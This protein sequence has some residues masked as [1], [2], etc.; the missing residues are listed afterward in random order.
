M[1]NKDINWVVAN[2]GVDVNTADQDFNEV[3]TFFNKKDAKLGAAAPEMLS[4]L[5]NIRDDYGKQI[6]AAMLYEVIALINK[7]AI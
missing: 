1:K 7:A 6:D 3:A 4:L 5:K 2:N